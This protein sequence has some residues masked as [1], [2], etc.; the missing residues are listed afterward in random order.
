MARAA[1]LEVHGVEAGPVAAGEIEI[2]LGGG[3]GEAIEAAVA[4]GVLA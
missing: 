1:I 2:G 4:E 3:V